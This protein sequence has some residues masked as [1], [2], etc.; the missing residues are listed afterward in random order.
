MAKSGINGV[1]LGAVAVGVVFVYGGLKGY[2]VL[3]AFQNIMQGQSAN[4][5]QD[6]S[7]LTSSTATLSP[8]SSGG[9]TS[10][11]GGSSAG[12]SVSEN[13]AIAKQRAAK[14]GWDTGA[15]WNALVSL[16]E[17]ESSWN[18]TIWNTSASCGNNAYAYGIVQACG[19]GERKN[20][21][22]HGS[23]CPYPAG[24]AGNPP[25]CGG[26]SNAGAQIDWG[27]SYIK[28]NYGAPVNVPHGGY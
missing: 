24:N 22:G 15:N 26:S 9:T 6:T 21:S 13:K 3:K 1:A 23:V 4:A 28:T 27:L 12:G 20:I 17:S 19:H 14:Y 7:L 11:A 5:G 18:N 16:W 25:E 2:S 8:D 10:S